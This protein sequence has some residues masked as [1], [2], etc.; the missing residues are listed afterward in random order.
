M[1]AKRTRSLKIIS[2]TTLAVSIAYLTIVYIPF[3]DKIFPNTYVSN[4]Y[5][6]D[7]T[8][9]TAL[10]YFKSKYNLPA[11]ITIDINGTKNDVLASEIIE[12]IDYEKT[13]DRAYNY[14]N[15][16]NFLSDFYTKSKLIIKPINLHPVINVNDQ[17][18]LETILILSNKVGKKPIYPSASLV[19]GE[20]IINAGEDGIEIDIEKTRKDLINSITYLKT[21]N[22]YV[23]LKEVK[24][25]LN[26]KEVESF[27]LESQKLKGKKIELKSDEEVYVIDDSELISFLT[28]TGFSDDLIKNKIL[29]ISKNL[30]RSP[31][32]SVFIVENERV[33]EFSPSKDGVTVDEKKLLAE[34]KSLQHVIIIPVVKVSPKIKT[35]DVNDL[36]IKTLLGR[37]YST[38]KGSIP[39]RIHNV[40]LAQSKFRGV[41]V[42]PNEVVSFNNILGDVS[43][44]T[45][46]KSAYVI[47]DGKTVLGDGGGVCQVSTTL[48]RAVLSAGLPVVERRAHAYRV[49][50]YEQG[51]GPGLDATVYSPTTDF[52]FKNNTDA[53]ILIQTEIDLNNLA[54]TFEI[55]GTD[56]GRIATTS[57]PVIT[58]QSSPAEDLYVDDP[59]LKA[60][61]I[62]QI[63]HR[64][65]GAKVIFDY[66]VIR[67][68]E[69]LINQKFVSNY[70]SWQAVYLRG[71]GI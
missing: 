58:S 53:Y 15:S 42:P 2:L 35:E 50:Y 71:T 65:Y 33:K 13:I 7:K 8:K 4:V 31:Q 38:F 52:K 64:A 24:I 26:S 22:I 28:P 1:T 40:N 12:G 47:M 57:K 36:G 69:E 66:K 59:T 5:L 10:N 44:Y 51:F 41:L 39:N 48:F 61:V 70:R 68:G 19:N 27:R 17:K 30:N 11:K 6:G 29:E 32:D 43:A 34:I 14:S 45:G 62:K 21:D 46:Y 3:W 9:V 63:E 56:D 25:K 54:L 23:E 49:G 18:F 16:G 20:I 60:G 37:G 55:Y 67:N